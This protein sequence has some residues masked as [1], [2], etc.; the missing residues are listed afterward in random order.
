[1]TIP[2]KL[3]GMLVKI[4][5][6]YGTDPTPTTAANGVR[7]SD[8][9]WPAFSMEHVYPN[10][11]ENSASG[12]LTPPAPALPAGAVG[13]LEI[14]CEVKG[15]GAAYGAT[16]RPEVDPLLRSV[17]FNDTI[18]STTKYSYDLV[19]TGAESCTIWL[20]TGGLLYKMS[21]CRGSVR[22]VVTPGEVSVMIF[23]MQGIMAAAVPT[24]IACPT[25]TYNATL[26]PAAIGMAHTIV[27][28]VGSW[29]PVFSAAEFDL[30]TQIS[31]RDS[32]N[33]ADGIGEF[34]ISG[35]TPR[36]T[37]TADVVA[38]TVFDPTTDLEARTS[39]PIDWTIG[40]T[41]YNKAELDLDNC[42]LVN[43]PSGEDSDSIAAYGLEYSMEQDDIAFVFE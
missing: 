12:L 25:I 29:S 18:T 24:A 19:S 37:E 8:R 3:D 6:T 38:L 7:V 31:R 20:Y 28:S 41:Q 4:E 39:T 36:F 22:W 10:L 1:M 26:P 13:T 2:I 40:P 42:W 33:G 17:G 9:I 21:G 15:F 16:D 35:Y 43:D 11:R 27:G 32:G 5:E 23:S 30:G 14:A 34:A